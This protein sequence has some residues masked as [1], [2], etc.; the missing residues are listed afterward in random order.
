MRSYLPL[1]LLALIPKRTR[2]LATLI[3]GLSFVGRITSLGDLRDV[4]LM[5]ADDAAYS[6]GVWRGVW[7]TKSLAAVRPAITWPSERRALKSE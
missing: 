4:P 1:V 5:I 3:V 2:R 6:T 7:R